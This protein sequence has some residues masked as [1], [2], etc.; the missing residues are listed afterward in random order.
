LSQTAL[1]EMR[2]LLFELHIGE[3][4]KNEVIKST[5]TG[6]ERIKHY[7]MLEALQLLAEDFSGEAIHVEIESQ[8]LMLDSETVETLRIREGIYRITQEALNNATKHAHAHQII[9]Q[10]DGSRPR[11]LSLSIRDDGV[12]FTPGEDRNRDGYE[13]GGFGMNTM[14]ERA[15]ELGG[16][17]KVISAPG[18]GTIVEVTIPLKDMEKDVEV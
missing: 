6:A 17:I 13:E 12:G 2:S 3:E 8:D 16:R 11:E 15:E 1:R 18:K 7:D 4:K 5:L 10:L 9:V 14:R